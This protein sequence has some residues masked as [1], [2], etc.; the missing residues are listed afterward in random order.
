MNSEKNK[1]NYDLNFRN[2]WKL[3]REKVESKFVLFVDQN[4]VFK[5]NIDYYFK[6]IENTI[7]VV[8]FF[9]ADD[10]F[11]KEFANLE[12]YQIKTKY[13][14]EHIVAVLFP[15]EALDAWCDPKWDDLMQEDIVD[16]IRLPNLMF[17]LNFVLQGNNKI[18]T[19]SKKKL[20]SPLSLKQ[21]EKPQYS[22]KKSVV[23]VSMNRNDRVIPC[24]E[25]W[26]SSNLFDDIVLVDWS[27]NPK[28]KDDPVI[29]D[30]LNNN[31]KINLIRV[32]D[33][34]YFNLCKSYNLAVDHAKNCDILKIDIDYVLRNEE[35]CKYLSSLDLSSSFYCTFEPWPFEFWGLLYFNK[36]HF[37]NAGRY[38]ENLNGWGEDDLDIARRLAK[39]TEKNKLE[40]LYCSC[41]YHIPHDDHLRTANYEIKDKW[42]SFNKNREFVIKRDRNKNG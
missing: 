3:N 42:H 21:S 6:E 23:V 36:N 17:K 28:I 5:G 1:R 14:V 20:P 38:D 8:E 4:V 2:F 33:Q 16:Q 24:L 10:S 25:S 41:V 9:I 26:A 22:N 35:F 32:D 39:V 40:K 27:S 30:F 12:K 29:N 11:Q 18:K 31:S 19:Y 15:R 37:N 13:M 7:S 34:K